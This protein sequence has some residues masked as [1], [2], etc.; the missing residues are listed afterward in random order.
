MQSRERLLAT[1]NHVEPDRACVDFGSSAVTGM[2]VRSVALLRE[3]YGLEQRPVKVCEPYQ[4][5]GEL[6]RDL[7]PVESGL[8]TAERDAQ[9]HQAIDQLP[10]SYR[11]LIMLRH[12]H[13]MSYAEIA[14]AAG[15]PL[16]TVKTGI[17]RARRSLRHLLTV[18][19]DS[20]YERT[21]N[22]PS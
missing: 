18:D 21:K 3:H 9:L 19:E 20:A 5:L 7:Q 12:L 2:H 8:E 16:G 11:L 1:I 14:E 13:G 15:I 4:M 10:E 6:D 22:E 17:F